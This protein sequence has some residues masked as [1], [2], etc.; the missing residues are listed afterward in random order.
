MSV[1]TPKNNTLGISEKRYNQKAYMLYHI[2]SFMWFLFITL[3]LYSCNGSMGSRHK[4]SN[5][6]IP[7]PEKNFTQYI[8]KTKRLIEKA[9]KGKLESKWVEARL[10]FE[11]KPNKNKCG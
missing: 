6:K 9:T 11:F 1:A 10:P 8:N 3:C 2:K 4:P 7:L 5:L